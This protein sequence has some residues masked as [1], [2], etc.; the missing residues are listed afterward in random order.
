MLKAKALFDCNADNDGEIS[1]KEGDIL[2]QVKK[3]AEDGWYEGRVEGTTAHGLFP[4]NY[5]ELISTTESTTKSPQPINDAF[6]AAMTRSSPK[7]TKT[8]PPAV[9]PK[10]IQFIAPAAFKSSAPAE[11]G[12]RAR[13]FS[14]PQLADLRS[15]RPSQPPV[16]TAVK[17][18]LDD[19]EEDEGY[20]L[21][22]PSQLRQQSINV[23]NR[24][25]PQKQTSREQ[26]LPQLAGH[27]APRL[28][29]RP[30][31]R[32]GRRSKLMKTT[33][34]T[35]NDKDGEKE[36]STT[37]QPLPPALKPK[38]ATPTL[39]PRPTKLRSASNPPLIR[40]AKPQIL[41]P[42]ENNNNNNNIK[43]ASAASTSRA[44]FVLP[45][46]IPRPAEDENVKPSS[47]RTRAMSTTTTPAGLAQKQ[48]DAIKLNLIHD[49]KKGGIPSPSSSSPSSSSPS[50]RPTPP[51]LPHRAREPMHLPNQKKTTQPPPPPPSRLPKVD[52]AARARYEGLFEAIHDEGFVDGDTARIIW[53]RSCLPEDTLARVWRE[54]D[55]KYQGLLDKQ[56]FVLG[57]SRIDELL[58]NFPNSFIKK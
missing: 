15:R 3:S 54:C 1:F 7:F 51:S 43:S 21:V 8:R 14:T 9:G 2:V 44:K 17:L 36:S 41:S 5:V 27:P 53:C 35:D 28:P 42:S 29:S 11:E 6:E 55:P 49:S 30:A 25:A 32:A 48:G 33:E 46:T 47:L 18:K 22:K 20:Q 24:C 23:S 16:P 26:P 10:P 4:F 13:S 38:P 34:M 50:S 31:L 39:P 37:S 58:Q 52:I 56:A 12:K 45:T 19:V 57:M 40:S